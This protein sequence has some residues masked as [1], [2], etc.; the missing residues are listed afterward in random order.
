MVTGLTPGR[1]ANRSGE[2]EILPD[3]TIWLI[4]GLDLPAGTER[5]RVDALPP[6][7]AMTHAAMDGPASG[8]SSPPGKR[9][10]PAGPE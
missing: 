4:G 10:D 3:G 1:Y 8:G 6:D 9:S 5:K 2:Y 7:A